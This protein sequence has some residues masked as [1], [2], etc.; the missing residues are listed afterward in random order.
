MVALLERSCMPISPCQRCGA[1][2]AIYKVLFPS[3]ETDIHPKGMVPADYAVE[4]SP[5]KSAMRGTEWSPRRCAALKGVIGE[6]VSCTIYSNRP[7]TCQL[8]KSAWETN[9]DS[10]SQCNRARGCYGLTPFSDY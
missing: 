3:F 6:S 9:A 4:V 10:G 5:T 1:C 8:F 7:S 2:C